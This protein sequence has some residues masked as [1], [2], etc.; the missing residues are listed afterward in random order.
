MAPPHLVGRHGIGCQ[1]LAAGEFV[2]IVARAHAAIDRSGIEVVGLC[3]GCAL[4]GKSLNAKRNTD[5]GDAAKSHGGLQRCV[6]HSN[7]LA[8]RR[9][10]IEIV[11]IS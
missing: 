10:V 8:G 3:G 6:V 4:L 1:P 9:K 7:G 2:E 11:A 5:H